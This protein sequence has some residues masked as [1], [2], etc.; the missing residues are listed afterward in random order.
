MNVISQRQGLINKAS[1]DAR[2]MCHMTTQVSEKGQS[3]YCSKWLICFNILRSWYN[4][5]FSGLDVI[6]KSW[7]WMFKYH[8][9]CLIHGQAWNWYC[10]WLSHFNISHYCPSVLIS[11]PGFLTFEHGDAA[12]RDTPS[13]LVF[14]I[15]YWIVSSAKLLLHLFIYL[16]FLR[17]LQ[18]RTFRPSTL[19]F[20][21]M[22]HQ[23]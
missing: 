12:G 19:N 16:F 23:P 21:V 3:S 14:C 15:H 13:T 6:A 18:S 5:I 2:A 4:M 1:I 9:H 10:C 7:L 11:C 22:P 8:I 17:G 20:P